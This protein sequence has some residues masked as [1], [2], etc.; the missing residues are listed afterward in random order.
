MYDELLED[1]IIPGIERESSDELSIEESFAIENQLDEKKT[2][3]VK[4]VKGFALNVKNL[5]NIVSNF[6]I[7]SGANL[8]INWI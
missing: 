3:M 2:M 5:N 1:E 7:S 8:N 6:R 4:N